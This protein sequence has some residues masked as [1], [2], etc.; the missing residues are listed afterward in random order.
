MTKTEKAIWNEL[1]KVFE[2]INGYIGAKLREDALF[3]RV[4]FYVLSLRQ[5]ELQDLREKI[6]IMNKPFPCSCPKGGLVGENE[7][8]C[9]RC[10]G[11]EWVKKHICAFNDGEHNCKCYDEAI[12]D[13]LSILTNEAI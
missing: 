9:D 10:G 5:K 6:E 12:K 13:I 7:L 8:P 3:D 1:D 4:L 2:D 11:S